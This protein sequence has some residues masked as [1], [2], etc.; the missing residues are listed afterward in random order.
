VTTGE[1]STSASEKPAPR[2]PTAMPNVS[3]RAN[4]VAVPD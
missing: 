3:A 1:A 4:G 2:T